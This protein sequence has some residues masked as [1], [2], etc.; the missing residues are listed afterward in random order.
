MSR[1]L[2]ENPPAT[3]VQPWHSLGGVEHICELRKTCSV[4]YGIFTELARMA[5]STLDGRLVGTPSVQWKPK[6][7]SMW[8]DSELRW[9]DEHPEVRP[10]IYVQL[11]QIQRQPWIPNV[12]GQVRGYDRFG[13]A[14]HEMRALGSVTFMHVASTVGEACAL[15]DNT[16]A[17]MMQFQTP[18][19]RDFCFANFESAGRVPLEKLGKEATEKYGSGVTFG[20]EFTDSWE[21]K[22]ECPVLK[23]VNFIDSGGLIDPTG[24][25][26]VKSGNIFDER[27]VRPV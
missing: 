4:L 1:N 8:I 2:P 26:A 17:F 16:E 18:I 13:H 27:R 5:Y 9:E 6:G 11:G 14:M 20:F 22:A 10:A 24:R 15:A 23:T 21:L 12:G 3:E 7:T 25:E 19:R